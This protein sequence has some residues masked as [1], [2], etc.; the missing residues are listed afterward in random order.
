MASHCE[1][2]DSEVEHSVLLEH[3]RVVGVPRLTDSLIGR[4]VVVVRSGETPVATRLLVGDHSGRRV[5][6]LAADDVPEA[7]TPQRNRPT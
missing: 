2:L 3:S 5:M 4:E 6:E 1:I 7:G